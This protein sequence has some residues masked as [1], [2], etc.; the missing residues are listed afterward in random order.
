MA[1]PYGLANQKMYYIQIYK[2]L[3]K[4]KDKEY[5]SEWLVNAGPGL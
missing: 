2:I 3:E 1:K 5:S 4:K